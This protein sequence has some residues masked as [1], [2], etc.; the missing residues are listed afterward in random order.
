M[1][2]I[3]CTED[4]IKYKQMEGK[5]TKC[6]IEKSLFENTEMEYMVFWVTQDGV[7]SIDNKYKQ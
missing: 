4:I 5:R 7:K 3:S 1:L 2:E 6:N